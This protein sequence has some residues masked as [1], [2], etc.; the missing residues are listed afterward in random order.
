MR[1]TVRILPLLLL[2]MVACAKSSNNT[3]ASSSPEA[4]AAA[5]PAA[6][7]MSASC[8]G[9]SHLSPLTDKGVKA[10]TGSTTTLEADN[11]NGQFY[12]EPSC[13]QGN[14]TLSV[15]VKNVGD[16]EHNFSVTSLGIDKDIEKGESVTVS[17]KL[18]ASGTLPFFCKY[19]KTSGMQG[20][21]IVR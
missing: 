1:W 13:V 10:A 16:V 6:S 19:H 9:L 7:A 8:A 17:V 14:G 2:A 12:F 4:S 18:P 3:A 15:T 21:F 5:T 11:D 20:A